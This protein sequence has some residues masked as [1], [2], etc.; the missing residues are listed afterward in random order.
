MYTN[1]H[2]QK[3]KQITAWW[4]TAAQISS[5]RHEWGLMGAGDSISWRCQGAGKAW[6]QKMSRKGTQFCKTEQ[7]VRREKKVIPKLPLA[8][9]QAPCWRSQTLFWGHGTY[10]KQACELKYLTRV[11]VKHYSALHD[12]EGVHLGSEKLRRAG[13][14]RGGRHEAGQVSMSHWVK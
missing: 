6:I 2:V 1:Y 4:G 10:S 13:P 7:R 8:L 3:S 11:T 14:I 12:D 5:Q 9:S